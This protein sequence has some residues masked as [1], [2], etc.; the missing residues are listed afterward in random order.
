MKKILLMLIL[1]NTSLQAIADTDWETAVATSNEKSLPLVQLNVDVS[2]L[3]KEEYIP[4]QITIYDPEKR[5]DGLLCDTF[6]CKLRYRGASSLKYEKKSF[7]VKL[8]DTEGD[9]LDANFFNIRKENDWILDAMAVDRIRMRNRVCFDLWNEISKTPYPTDFDNRN[10]TKGEYVEVYLNGA[11]HGLYCMSDKIDRKLLGLKK[12]KE[13]TDSNVIIRGVLYKGEAWSAATQFGGYD[14]QENMDSETWNGWELQYPDDYPCEEAW[15][16]LQQLIDCCSGNVSLFANEYKNRF[17]PDNLRDYMLF[18]MSLNIIDN[19]M[20]NTHISCPNIQEYQV[21]LITPWDLDCSLGGLY[22]GSHYEAYTTMSNLTNN[23]IYD[24][25]YTGD[26]DGFLDDMKRR[27]TELSVST[28]SM[29]HVY[30]KMDAYASKMKESGAWQREYEKWNNNPVPLNLD[31]E[32]Q[33]VKDWYAQNL[34]TLDE[35]LGSDTSIQEMPASTDPKNVDTYT[36]DGIK[37]RT[38]RNS[39]CYIIGNRKVFR[40]LF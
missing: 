29:E 36:L 19:N 24:H 32:L 22:D 11:Y 40:K 35:I 9:D 39:N 13:N 1:A 34:K 3:T 12:V 33:Y 10:G 14:K 26:V 6:D 5:V 18:L 15:S 2:K 37:R 21:F 38:N 23:R 17:Y 31:E 27:W 30:G 28:L 20:K 25:L 7:A 4:G 8:L 16:P